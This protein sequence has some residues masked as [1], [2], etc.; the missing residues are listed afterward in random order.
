MQITVDP[1]AGYC[2][3]VKNAIG[4][5]EAVL[6]EDE[7]LY[8]LGHLVH[9]SEEVRRLAVNGLQV[10][11]HEE[12][13]RLQNCKVLIRAHGE[14]PSTYE[15]AYRNNI[16]LIDATCPIVKHLQSNIRKRVSIM[17]ETNSQVAIYGK[18]NH[19]EVIG[20]A[21]H[22]GEVPLIIQDAADIQ[23]IDPDKDVHLY[24]QTTMDPAGLKNIADKITKY[25]SECRPGSPKQVIV[26]NT[27]C[28][29]VTSRIKHLQKFAAFN[30][31]VLFV[32]GK[33]SSNGKFLFSVCHGANP[34]S[35]HIENESEIDPDWFENA[36][37]VGI[38][39][40]T[41]TPLWQLNAVRDIINS[42]RF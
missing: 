19:P 22:A 36:E 34:Q 28:R 31:V 5:A 21:G 33:K 29:Q 24:A 11:S 18:H 30:D 17:N 39:G 20:L 14:P 7:K 27:I 40:A 25:L 41:S 35:Y 38:T 15:T 6:G 16:I 2:F 4:Q 42:I 3:G 8:S 37:K 13:S 26:H 10:I 9:N 1:K 12:F 32:S 23:K